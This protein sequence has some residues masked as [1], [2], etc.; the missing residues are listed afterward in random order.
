MR[1]LLVAILVVSVALVLVI[2]QV[3]LSQQMK[4]VH[5]ELSSLREQQ[6]HT[7]AGLENAAEQLQ[8]TR[9]SGRSSDDL[10][11]TRQGSS[12]LAALE[13]Q[14]WDLNQALS[15]AATSLP[16]RP[17]V[18]EYDPNLPPPP[19]PP[20]APPTNST[21]RGWGPEQ[22]VGPPD[23]PNAGDYTTA[24]ASREPDGGPEWLA[25][26]FERA[27]E[28]AE[29]RIRES[30]NPGA[31][32][33]VVALVNNQETVLWEGQSM[34]G[35]APRDFVVRPPANVSSQLVTVYL[36]TAL[37][38][39]W[40]EIDAAEL[41]GRDGSRQWAASASASTSFADRMLF[42]GDQVPIELRLR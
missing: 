26:G 7:A 9:S 35:Q 38:P 27:V 8:G 39:G 3:R 14:V 12:R 19:E 25:V 20:A 1:T 21:S 32:V 4:T 2:Q 16:R 10:V 33:K 11:A 17:A 15:R 29:V 37:V 40:N 18:P 24:W 6:E 28:I 31:I 5:Q 41:V 30:Y 36:D 34:R 22:V 13:K 23:T 42:R